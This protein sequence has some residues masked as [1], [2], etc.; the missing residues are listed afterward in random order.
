MSLLALILPLY[1]L[2]VISSVIIIPT[3]MQLMVSASVEDATDD[4]DNDIE[5]TR[6]ENNED[7]GSSDDKHKFHKFPP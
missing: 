1:L 4:E 3:P 7:D 6:D 5:N 2:S